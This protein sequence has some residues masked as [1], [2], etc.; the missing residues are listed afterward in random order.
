MKTIKSGISQ[1]KSILIDHLEQNILKFWLSKTPD[2]ENGGFYGQINSENKAVADANKGVILN[3]RILWTF[4]AAYGFFK[5]NEY[6]KMAERA[7]SYI[8][9]HFSDRIYGGVYW[10]LDYRGMPVN[11]RKQ[12]YAQ[13]FAIYSFVEYFNICKDQNVLQ[14]AIDIYKLIEKNSLDKSENGYIDAFAE[15]WSDIADLRLSDKDLNAPKT[16]NTH[17]HIL[18]AYT[19]L[20]RVWK[21]EYLRK[22]LQNLIVIFLEKFIDERG[23]LILFF[24]RSWNKMDDYCSY[25]HD[26]EF[27][28]LITEAALVLGDENLI[29]RTENTAKEI[30]ELVRKEGLDAD[31]AIMYE[32]DYKNNKADTD[33][34]WWM[35]A[36]A[37]VGFLNIYG[38]SGDDKYLESLINVWEFTYKNMVDH[39]NG[40][41]F[42][43]TDRNGNVYPGIEKAGFWKC[44]Y[45]NSRAILE[46]AERFEKNGL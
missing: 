16:M 7:Y 17:L 32:F 34:H 40:E 31:G 23:H 39:Q 9:E 46:L 35:Q 19:N 5:S 13:A 24:D 15:D 26:I 14:K 6:Q 22:S 11:K 25:G 28:W 30:A 43:R 27:S 18:E 36:E 3:T 37:M 12:I 44:P 45:H 2:F 29:K 4:S 41:W 38:I 21:N 42:W 8:S 20:Y 33:K 10:E 1:L